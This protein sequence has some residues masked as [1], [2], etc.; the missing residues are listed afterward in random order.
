MIIKEG[1]KINGLQ[2]QMILAIFIIA[3]VYED[4]GQELVITSA[5]DSIHGKNSLHYVGYAIDIRTNFFEK[6]VIPK[7]AHAISEKLG[8][9]FDVIVEETHIHVEYQPEV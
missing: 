3:G 7:V 9:Q 4:F 8:E 1:V 2:P 5:T 6:S